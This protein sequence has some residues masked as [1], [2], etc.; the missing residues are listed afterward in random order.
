MAI[1]VLLVEDAPVVLLLL[2]R[3]LAAATDIKVVGTAANG[4]EALELIPQLDPQVICTDL[5]MP[6]MD[7][8]ELTDEIMNRF[9]RPILVLSASVQ[10]DE[11]ENVFRAFEA[12]A[13]DILPKPFAGMNDEREHLERELLSKI[14]VLA[15][16]VVF[17][18]HGTPVR[19]TSAPVSRLP[20]ARPDSAITCQPASEPASPPDSKP[21]PAPDP[22]PT[23]QASVSPTATDRAQCP[24]RQIVTI[25]ASTGG[26]Q[27]LSKIFKALPADF[28]API[29]CT[30]HIS[31]GFLAG[32]VDW[33]DA[34]CAL[35]VRVARAGER[36]EAGRIYFAPETA[37]LAIDRSGILRCVPGD[38]RDG[39]FPSVTVMFE[40]VARAFR[41]RATGVLLTGMGRD[42]ASGLLEIAQNGGRTIAQDASSCVVFGMPKEAIALQ[43]AQR[44]LPIDEIGEALVQPFSAIA[45]S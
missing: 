27:A 21:A 29:L 36:A 3:M 7:G 24:S 31:H 34:D 33:L 20:F 10:A 15:G 9:P 26:P 12:G 2:E 37:H 40:A 23:L 22:P 38:P 43:A 42:G 13:V 16:V 8:W 6:E 35:S 19:T 14:R 18:R 11:T 1:R 25:G 4:K 45:K 17:S 39:H 30:Q 44:V 5:H 32:L 28:P 41:D